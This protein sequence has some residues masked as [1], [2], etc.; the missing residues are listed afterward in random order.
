MQLQDKIGGLWRT[1]E[2]PSLLRIFAGEQRALGE[3]PIVREDGRAE[4]MGYGA[5]LKKFIH[6]K[7]SLIDSLRAD[8][9]LLA[10]GLDLA[11]P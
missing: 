2:Y 3:A 11:A 6:G 8:I 4:C 9:A 10:T 7:D 5:F 1:D